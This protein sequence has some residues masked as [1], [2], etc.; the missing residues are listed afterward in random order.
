MRNSIVSWAVAAAIALGVPVVASSA[1]NAES[2]MRLC[3]TQWKEA[4]GAGTTGGQTWPQFLAQCR[5]SQNGA[6]AAP[7]SAPAPAQSGSLI[8]WWQP[9]APGFRAGVERRRRDCGSERHATMREP[10]ERR[11][12][13]GDDRRPDLAAVSGAMPREPL[14]LG[15]ALGRFRSGSGAGPC[16][17]PLPKRPPL[18]RARCF[19][20]GSRRP[21]R[22]RPT[23]ALLPPCERAST[24]PSF[25]RVRPARQ[26]RSC[27]STRRRAST[28]IREPTITGT[29]AGAPICAKP[30]RGR[31]DFARRGIANVRPRRLRAEGAAHGRRRA[32]TEQL[33]SGH[34]LFPP[35][36][37]TASF[38]ARA[39]ALFTDEIRP[40][41]RTR[42][43]VIERQN[44]QRRCVTRLTVRHAQFMPNSLSPR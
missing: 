25:R 31:A 27:G 23:P 29:H 8:P 41:E 15:L 11:Q 44:Y 36:A 38:D 39:A 17:K 16:A 35:T 2:V 42:R 26:T 20:G 33:V 19:H 34:R 30:M 32:L 18:S 6:A 9:S 21:T 5:A 24:R 3:A 14:S 13:G 22:R 4:Q 12:G 10:M 43:V 7:A 40:A 37:L 28:T 1:A